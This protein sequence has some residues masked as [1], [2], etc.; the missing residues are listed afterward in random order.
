MAPLRIILR[1]LWNYIM[2]NFHEKHCQCDS[3]IFL[4]IYSFGS[5]RQLLSNLCFAGGKT[6]YFWQVLESIHKF[7]L[8][9]HVLQCFFVRG[10]DEKQRRGII[11]NFTI[12]DFFIS[13]I[14]QVL[15]SHHSCTFSKNAFFPLQFGQDDNISGN[16]TERRVYWFVLKTARISPVPT[17]RVGIGW[18]IFS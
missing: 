9:L 13:Y 10:S 16:P 18:W 3:I 1:I 7:V 11:S 14:N 8:E 2:K 6:L 17:G 12:G 5:S 4:K 15:R